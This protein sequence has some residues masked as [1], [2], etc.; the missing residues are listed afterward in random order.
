MDEIFRTPKVLILVTPKLVS[1]LK[2]IMETIIML[3][4]DYGSDL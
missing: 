1:N 2:F 4:N 3:T